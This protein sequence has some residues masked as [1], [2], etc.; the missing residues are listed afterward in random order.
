MTTTTS[1]RRAR[2]SDHARMLDLW[3]RSARATH[4]FLTE[5]DIVG[6]RPHVA[7]EFASD[8]IGWWVLVNEADLAIGFLG[9][10]ND[11]I[12]GLFIDPDHIGLG[13]GKHLVEYAQHLS[14][15]GLKV[16]V[17]EQNT[18]AVGFYLGLGFRVVERS[19][20]DGAGRPF[21]LLHLQRPRSQLAGDTR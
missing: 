9:F 20:T 6:L 2:T 19:A 16:D 10:A 15:G 14:T 11:A 17:N 4:H 12:E 3:E 13:A 18:A 8:A 5:P 21:P 1:V 7:A